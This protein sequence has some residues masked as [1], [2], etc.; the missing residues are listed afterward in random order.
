PRRNAYGARARRFR[1]NINDV[2]AFAFHIQRA[3]RRSFCGEKLAAVRKAV[4]RDIQHT[5]DKSALPQHQFA[6]AQLE[7][8]GFSERHVESESLAREVAEQGINPN[9]NREW[10]CR[11]ERLSL[12]SSPLRTSWRGCLL[13][14]FPGRPNP[15]TCLRVDAFVP[16]GCLR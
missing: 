5:H 4:W 3:S 9:R 12:S 15:R 10:A 7:L 14:A 6:A 11:Q 8:V 2:R 13:C 16:P 1:A